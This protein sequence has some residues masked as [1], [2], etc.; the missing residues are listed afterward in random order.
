MQA[1]EAAALIAEDEPL[2]G[3]HLQAELAAIWPELRVVAN[4]GHG[5][6]AV[7]Q[8]LALRPDLLFLDIRMP[9]L[10]GLEAAH[11]L[12]EDWPQDVPPPLTVFVTAY[13][14]Y[15]VQAFEQQAID[16]VLKPVQTERLVQT[17]RR[18]QAALARR[19]AVQA[20]ADRDASLETTLAQLRSLLAAPGLGLALPPAAA[21]TAP[22]PRL[23]VIQASVG[24]AIHMVPV[25]EVLYFEAADKY[26]RVVTAQREHLI[27][28]SLRD[29]LPQLDPARFW[30][31]H[32]GT[33]VRCD[34]I[35]TAVRE[36]SGKVTL[37]LR[38]SPDRL[39]A[40]RLYAHL[41]KAM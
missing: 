19:A 36:E 14:Q 29:L 35:V 26:V 21:A 27:R 37:T 1:I 40:S 16:Y 2:L 15:A 32:R 11:A 30:Q 33:V 39:T 4:V 7:E 28:A 23:Q 34:A 25:D 18:L 38:G 22:A 12:A 41:F 13:D 10:S 6:A 31:V 17:C 24:T 8:A 20:P 9:G 5:A 3:A